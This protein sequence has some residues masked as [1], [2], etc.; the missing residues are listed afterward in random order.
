VVVWLCTFAPLMLVGYG[1][2]TPRELQSLLV[3]MQ[4]NLFP[5]YRTRM[6]QHEAGHFLMA[7]LLGLPIQGYHT[8]AVRH[9]VEFYPLNDPNVGTD[10][11]SRLGFDA[12]RDDGVVSDDVPVQSNPD[13]PFFSREGRGV[14]T[15]ETRSVFRKSN[16]KNF[17]LQLPSQMEPTQAWPYRGIT[18]SK[19]D[20]LA[21]VSVAGV[22]AEILAF[23]NAEGGVADFSQLR[24]LF[25]ATEPELTERD[26]EHRIRFAVG[27][28][29]TQLRLH[30]GAL[31]VLAEVMDRGGS[32]AECI[33]AIETC[34]NVSG[35]DGI[36]GDY[37]V[38]RRHKF[39]SLGVNVLE[40]LLLSEKTADAEETR[41]VQ[42]AGG[43]YKK[44]HRLIPAITGDDPLYIALGVAFVF[45]AWA[46][47]GGLSLH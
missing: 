10:R 9:A 12:P 26:M 46:T 43:G 41:F 27:F 15:M 35:Q 30:L 40:K 23:G 24:Q 3:A 21:V 38:R 8:N 29:M 32:V 47:S 44:E 20:Q 37:D 42:G 19:M 22:C 1:I 33:K 28:A 4:R 31:D 18:H 13:A 5:T 25:A 45:L 7:H 34:P 16:D 11:A 6:L 17:F 39:R 14:A 36:T 2:A